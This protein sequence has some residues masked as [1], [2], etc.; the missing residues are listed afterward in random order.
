MAEQLRIQE[1]ERENGQLRRQLEHR[2]REKAA[3]RG[4]LEQLQR[5]LEEWKRGHRVRPR[6]ARRRPPDASGKKPGCKPGHVGHGRPYPEEAEVAREEH[7]SQAH[8]PRCGQQVVPTGERPTQYVEALVPARRRV[9]A[10]RQDGYFCPGC[11]HAGLTSLPPE[12]GPAPKLAVS[13]QAEV[14]SLH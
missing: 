7:H 2:E 13:V 12:L 3:L 8:C 9:V 4:Q 14:V 11:H 1:L 10:Q 6:R 5:E